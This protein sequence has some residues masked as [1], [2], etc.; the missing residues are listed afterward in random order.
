MPFGFFSFPKKKAAISWRLFCFYSIKLRIAGWEEKT[1]NFVGVEV[2]IYQRLL[3]WIS[4]GNLTKAGSWEL[5][6]GSG[7]Q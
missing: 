3:L 7:E 2:V 5:G 1:A 4:G 6:A